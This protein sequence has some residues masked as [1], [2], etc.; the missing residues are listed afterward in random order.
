[1]S[2][3]LLIATGNLGSDMTQETTPNG[4]VIGKF[5]MAM[6]SGYG[7]YEKTT[8]LGVKILGGL[9]NA[10]GPYLK[11]G[12]KVTITG[13]CELQ[14]WDGNDGHHHAKLVVTA[15]DVELPPR[16]QEQHGSPAYQAPNPAQPQQ[17]AYQPASKPYNPDEFNDDGIPF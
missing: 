3:N 10:I 16:P 8:W 6:K 11:K 17:P 2:I 1:M 13:E 4:K 5:S 14:E 15:R 12:I 7:E 9:V